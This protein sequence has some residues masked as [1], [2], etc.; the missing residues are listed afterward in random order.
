MEIFLS[1]N[2]KQQTKFFSNFASRKLVE[3]TNMENCEMI[4]KI[5][6]QLKTQDDKNI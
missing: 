3:K 6:K 4:S 1:K 5:F 2:C